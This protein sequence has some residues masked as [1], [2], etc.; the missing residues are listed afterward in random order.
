MEC[1]QSKSNDF[2]APTGQP[3]MFTHKLNFRL[4][5]YHSSDL[6]SCLIH[7]VNTLPYEIFKGLIFFKENR[8]VG[9][10]LI[11]YHKLTAKDCLWTLV[12]IT[13]YLEY[14]IRPVSTS[15]SQW[16]RKSFTWSNE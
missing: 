13:I 1:V 14:E 6:F 3:L 5:F 7:N 4:N 11:T 10:E 16:D 15:T 9:Y 2:S 12:F 8:G